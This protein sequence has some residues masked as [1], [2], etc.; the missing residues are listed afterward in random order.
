MVFCKIDSPRNQWSALE[1]LGQNKIANQ[2]L[3]IS[4]IKGF[5]DSAAVI[6]L[7]PQYHPNWLCLGWFK[8]RA[9]VRSENLLRSRSALRRT[10]LS[11]A[12]AQFFKSLTL[13]FS[14]ALSKQCAPLNFALILKTFLIVFRH[15]FIHFFNFWLPFQ[16]STF[17]AN[18]RTRIE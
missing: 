9:L 7:H 14:L 16:R 6:C 5:S 17:K 2:G 4:Y 15:K 18:N 3:S 12:R 1:I 13:S 10:I 11:A 8:C